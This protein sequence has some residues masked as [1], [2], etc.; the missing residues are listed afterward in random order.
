MSSSLIFTNYVAETIDEIVERLQPS[1]IHVLVDVNTEAFVLPLLQSQS[2]AVAAASVIAIK[3]GEMFK[4]LDTV[5]AIWKKLSDGEANR[6]SLLINL[7]GGV[8]TDMGAFAAASFKR[9]IAFI[10]VPTTLL[11][12]VDASVGGK[13]GFNFNGLKN[14]IGFFRDADV[15]IISTIFFNTLT[16]QELLSGYAEMLKH[17][18]VESE[19]LTRKML[20]YD[21]TNYRPESLLELLKES[22]AVKERYVEADREDRGARRA[23]NF[24][25]T[26]G[27]AFES[28]A[29]KRKSPLNHGYAV[30]FGMVV[31]LVQSRI[32]YDFS[33][34]LLNAYV[35]YV[36]RHYGAFEISCADY[37][38]LLKFMHHDKKNDRK[39]AIN[40]TLLRAPGQVEVN[41]PQTDADITAALD[42]YRDLLGLP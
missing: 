7:G 38:E 15:A 12:A 9:G 2:K 16:S 17:G 19:E 25:H 22:V 23:L 33:S 42:I 39:D 10:N 27:H 5:S 28:L 14:E 30:A 24:G 11:C 3:A 40:C 21:V 8:V 32:K 35:D 18:F 20:A 29:M 34:D 37:P 13:T 6:R 36:K 41:V 31:A 26:I 4:N 1:S